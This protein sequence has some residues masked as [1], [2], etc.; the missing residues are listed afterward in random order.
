MKYLSPTMIAE[1]LLVNSKTNPGCLI[2]PLQLVPLIPFSSIYLAYETKVE[3]GY[4]YCR[5]STRLDQFTQ[6]MLGDVVKQELTKIMHDSQSTM[7]RM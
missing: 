2:P 5:D 1:L 3:A 6:F 7:S 4:N